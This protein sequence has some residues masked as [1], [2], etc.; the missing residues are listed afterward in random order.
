MWDIAF[1]SGANCGTIV[2]SSIEHSNKESFQLSVTLSMWRLHPNR[3]IARAWLFAMVSEKY[4]P[5]PSWQ[6]T[7]AQSDEQK[8]HHKPATAIIDHKIWDVD[9]H[10]PEQLSLVTQRRHNHVYKILLAFFI[11]LLINIE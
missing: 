10:L 4:F 3:R 9:M 7:Q 6:G 8:R 11:A 2:L 5:S 1:A